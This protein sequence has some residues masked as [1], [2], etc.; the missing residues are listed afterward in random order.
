MYIPAVPYVFLPR[1]QQ[2]PPLIT[3]R[4]TI[5]NAKYVA[6]QR[7]A[8]L[9]GKPPPDF[10]QF[11]G[12]GETGFIRK[13]LEEHIESAEGRSAMGLKPFDTSIPG[14]SVGEKEALAQANAL[15]GLA[16]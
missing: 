2:S 4:L 5:A 11:D 8:F 3:H 15:F 1:Q 7:D 12:K 13:G 9:I 16:S 14:L 6:R 10:P